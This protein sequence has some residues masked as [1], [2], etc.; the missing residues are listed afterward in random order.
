MYLVKRRQI[1]Q[2]GEMC[3]TSRCGRGSF[4]EPGA[5]GHPCTVYT[6]RQT[7]SVRTGRDMAVKSC[8]SLPLTKHFPGAHCKFKFCKF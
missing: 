2:P 4:P 3:R 1:E 5:Q 6:E 8:A 7:Q